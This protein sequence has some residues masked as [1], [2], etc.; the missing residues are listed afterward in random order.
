MAISS[1]ARA[2]KEFVGVASSNVC[3]S[4]ERL[5]DYLS[6]LPLVYESMQF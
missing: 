2:F 5:L 1:A 6:I 3:K 4:D